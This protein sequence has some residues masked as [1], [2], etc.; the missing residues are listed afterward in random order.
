MAS[1]AVTSIACAAVLAATACTCGSQEELANASGKT[2]GHMP[3][4]LPPMPAPSSTEHAAPK[5]DAAKPATA[6]DAAAATAELSW[7]MPP[8]W[9]FLGS[10]SL[11]PVRAHF[12]AAEDGPEHVDVYVVQQIA[13]RGK[14][15]DE[16]LRDAVARETE[17]FAKVESKDVTT[18]ASG[19]RTLTVV[20]IR[21]VR[22]EPS[23][24][25]KV[26]ELPNRLQVTALVRT[27]GAPFRIA[28]DGRP[29]LVERS[30]DDFFRFVDTMKIPSR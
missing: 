28:M 8:A 1:L 27:T 18:R 13:A 4:E 26:K 23:E 16:R 10:P 22:R 14:D 11:G 7:T 17:G 29:D 15:A 3:P 19:D 2:E 25:R 24:G 21:G 20:E 9:R 30:R 5:S 6:N 12:Y